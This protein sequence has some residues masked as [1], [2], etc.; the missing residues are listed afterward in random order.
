MVAI[1]KNDRVHSGTNNTPFEHCRGGGCESAGRAPY[2][3]NRW[4]T[5][6]SRDRKIPGGWTGDRCRACRVSARVP[7]AFGKAADQRGNL[8]LHPGCDNSDKTGA[9]SVPVINPPSDTEA[10][11]RAPVVKTYTFPGPN[12]TLAETWTTGHRTPCGL[13]FAPDGRLWNSWKTHQAW[14]QCL[15]EIRL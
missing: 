14:G 15:A 10:A 4:R 12:L 8:V 7:A 13:A 6:P 2:S 5:R 11:K 1:A 3:Q 9:A